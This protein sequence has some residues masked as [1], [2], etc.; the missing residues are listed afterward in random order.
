SGIAVNLF[1]SGTGVDYRSPCKYAPQFSSPSTVA[2][3]C[4]EVPMFFNGSTPAT[5]IVAAGPFAEIGMAAD[6]PLGMHYHATQSL[7]RVGD[8]TAQLWVRVRSV[9]S[10]L[11]GWV[12]S[13]YD[14]D[15][16]G[17]L[18]LYFYNSSGVLKFGAATVTSPSPLMFDGA[19]AAYPT[20]G[21]W[22]FIRV[23]H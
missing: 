18:G 3:P 20:D 5:P 21:A 14:L 19:E 12:F 22:H 6:I 16:G 8:V 9:D 23:V 15:S 1:I 17:G 4:G 10:F 7:Q 2:N 11:S 13:D